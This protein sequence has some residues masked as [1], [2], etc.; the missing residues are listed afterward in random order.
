MDD[1]LTWDEIKNKYP[2]CNVGLSNIQYHNNSGKI[3]K[4]KVVCTDKNVDRNEM[5]LQ[6]FQGKIKVRY[7]TFDEDG[8]LSRRV[9][10]D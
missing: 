10:S 1:L 9:V 3:L 8:V 6:A 2:H 7:T 5:L 4:A